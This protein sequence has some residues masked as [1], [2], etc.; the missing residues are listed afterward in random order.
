MSVKIEF[1]GD[2]RSYWSKQGTE[3]VDGRQSIDH[4][5][6]PS[7]EFGA[8]GGLGFHPSRTRSAWIVEDVRFPLPRIAYQHDLEQVVTFVIHPVSHS[9]SNS[10]LRSIHR[11]KKNH[12]ESKWRRNWWRNRYRRKGRHEARS[13]ARR[14]ENSTRSRVRWRWDR[15]GSNRPYE[16]TALAR[17]NRPYSSQ[18]GRP[19]K[20]LFGHHT[21]TWAGRV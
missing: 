11:P 10:S 14:P 2:V 7:G 6:G 8:D 4:L 21:G 13:E 5:E 18:L 9:Y 17:G 16:G 3:E 19:I 12:T 1:E 20:A 15:G